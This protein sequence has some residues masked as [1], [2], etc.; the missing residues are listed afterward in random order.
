MPPLRLLL[1][2]LLASTLAA[3]ARAPAPFLERARGVP[4]GNWTVRFENGVVQ[5]C[6]ITADGGVRVVEPHRNAAGKATAQRGVAMITCE[7]GRVER[8]TLVEGSWAVEH[9]F[10]A[11]A[12]GAGRPVRGVA[13]RAR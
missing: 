9:W 8:W 6:A 3:S 7:D 4:S 5:T 2:T 12:Y 10:P 1:A 11:A 13:H